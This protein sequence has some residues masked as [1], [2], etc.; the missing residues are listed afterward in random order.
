[1]RTATENSPYFTWLKLTCQ[2]VQKEV[3]MAAW[4][5][6]VLATAAGEA[7]TAS[8]TGARMGREVREVRGLVLELEKR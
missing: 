8:V 7:T 1:M 2:S 6:G 3:S 4:R 5:V